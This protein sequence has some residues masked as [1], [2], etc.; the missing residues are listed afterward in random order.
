MYRHWQFRVLV[1]PLIF[2]LLAGCKEQEEPTRWDQVQEKTH[3]RQEP[4][5]STSSV[6][7]GDL[8]RFFPHVTSPFD[9]VFKQE[10]DGLAQASLQ[11][12][13]QEL[14]VLSIADTT[15]NPSAKEK[16][17]SSTQRLDGHPMAA[18]GSKGT[19]ILVA[20][21]YQIQARSIDPSF[22]EAERIEWL[23]KFD[24]KRLSTL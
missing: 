23:Q 2:L 5:V 4:A 19:A 12:D 14:A 7:G 16:Y 9:L 20:D 3:G 24:L 10:K 18:A 21:R 8:N 13:G 17:A 1:V 11:K 6:A 22:G 15:N